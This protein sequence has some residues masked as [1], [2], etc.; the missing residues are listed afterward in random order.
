[1]RQN[2][3]LT[4]LFAT[5]LK[6]SS[7]SKQ[8]QSLMLSWLAESSLKAHE[9]FREEHDAFKNRLLNW[10]QNMCEHNR[11]GK[12]NWGFGSWGFVWSFL[13]LMNNPKYKNKLQSEEP[14]GCIPYLQGETYHDGHDDMSGRM[15]PHHVWKRENDQS[16]RWIKRKEKDNKHEVH[17]T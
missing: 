7:W 1:M 13:L 9:S 2:K 14:E 17:K 4:A 16:C 11:A 8:D 15:I 6:R 3:K 10:I 12:K 5:L